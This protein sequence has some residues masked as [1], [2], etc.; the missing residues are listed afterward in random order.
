KEELEPFVKALHDMVL[1]DKKF[2]K[3]ALAAEDGNKEEAWNTR[4]KASTLREQS[5]NY[6]RP[7]I[8]GTMKAKPAQKRLQ[9][10]TDQVAEKVTR[11]VEELL[12]LDVSESEANVF[13]NVAD[14]KDLSITERLAV[15]TIDDAAN[16]ELERNEYSGLKLSRIKDLSN[17]EATEAD[18]L[19]L[20]TSLNG[21]EWEA[22]EDPGKPADAR[23]VR[24]VNKTAEPIEF[25]LDMFKVESSEVEPKSVADKNVEL[26]E[27]DPFNLLDGDL[28]TYT[29]F[30][31]AQKKG[32]YI[33]YNLGQKIDLDSLKVYVQKNEGDFPRHA[34]IESSLDGREWN[35]VMTLGN[36]DGPNEGEKNDQ[37][38]IEDVFPEV[39]DEYRTKE[40]TDIDQEARF[41][42]LKVTRTKQGTG[43]WLRMQEIQINDGA[44]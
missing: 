6:D 41:L 40:V 36:Q 12:D 42:R 17:I 39:Q 9:P 5:L 31:A 23:Y 11:N 27:S 18:G 22:V 15:T 30:A 13:T 28:S 21:I 3:A 29:W 16:I 25:R 19:R 44:F 4:M 2:I 43:N 14:Y 8:N 26:H 33:T 24:L 38:R 10:F 34:V 35:T 1:A 37:D 20:E 32:Q 7:L